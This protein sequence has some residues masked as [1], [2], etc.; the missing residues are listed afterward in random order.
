MYS[1]KL[2]STGTLG[3]SYSSK[4]FGPFKP[5]G[6][7][8]HIP[9][10]FLHISPPSQPQKVDFGGCYENLNAQCF[11]AAYFKSG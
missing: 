10:T 4:F 1:F 11:G 2:S 8:I 6:G 5:S 7:H 9:H 3:D